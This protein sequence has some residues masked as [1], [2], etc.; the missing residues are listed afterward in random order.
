MDTSS[1]YSYRQDGSLWVVYAMGAFFSLLIM[2]QLL[3]SSPNAQF[4]IILIVIF[5]VCVFWLT[6]MSFAFKYLAIE[7]ITIH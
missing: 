4:T 2:I 5:S 1:D 7:A 3:S 6:I